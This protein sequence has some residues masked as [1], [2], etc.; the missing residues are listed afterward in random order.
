MDPVYRYSSGD[1]R[2]DM[3]YQCPARLTHHLFL[4][5]N[6]LS[7]TYRYPGLAPMFISRCLQP[8]THH[9]PLLEVD[10]L[11]ALRRDLGLAWTLTSRNLSMTHSHL[12]LEV[13]DPVVH[14]YPVE[15]ALTFLQRY[16][17]PRM[18][19]N[20]A[21]WVL[22]MRINQPITHQDPVRPT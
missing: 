20:P 3:E 10:N 17:K 5:N 22:V 9:Y 14:R 12:S 15:K 21:E 16:S 6:R 13:G 19:Q 2:G 8:K 7:R 1:R 18:R 11:P 4:E